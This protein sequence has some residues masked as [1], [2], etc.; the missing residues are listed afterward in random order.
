[1]ADGAEGWRMQ[2]NKGLEDQRTRGLKD[3][4][5]RRSGRTSRT[6]IIVLYHKIFFDPKITFFG[7]SWPKTTLGM[8]SCTNGQCLHGSDKKT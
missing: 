3:G 6:R 2:G 1:M 8:G 7:C 5:T 4:W